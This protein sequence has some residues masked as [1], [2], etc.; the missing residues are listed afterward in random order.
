MATVSCQERPLR[1]CLPAVRST[2]QLL[3]PNTRDK[4][5]FLACG[6]L[7]LSLKTK[8]RL[9]SVACKGLFSLVASQRPHKSLLAHQVQVHRCPSGALCTHLGTSAVTLRLGTA[10]HHL[11]LAL[12]ALR[13][14]FGHPFPHEHI[15]TSPAEEQASRVSACVP[16]GHLRVPGPW[17]WRAHWGISA[18]V[19]QRG[20]GGAAPSHIGDVYA[21]LS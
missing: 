12:R 1:D 19:S 14:R 13:P 10:A 15:V 6:W 8:P 5:K 11:V 17:A 18:N 3:G 9:L 4:G 2:Q 16:C 20:R 7:S 21:R